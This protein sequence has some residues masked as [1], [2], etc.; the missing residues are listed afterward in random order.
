MTTTL[1]IVGGYAAV[2]LVVGLV[3]AYRCALDARLAGKRPDWDEDAPAVV[4]LGL[5][6]LPALVVWAAMWAF[7]AIGSAIDAAATAD[8]ESRRLDEEGG[9]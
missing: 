3:I 8:A 2:G 6:W 9:K 5:L 1:I 7:R 4:G